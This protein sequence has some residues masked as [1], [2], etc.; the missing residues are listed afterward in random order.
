MSAVPLLANPVLLLQTK[1][2]RPHAYSDHLPRPRLTQQLNQGLRRKLTLVAAPAGYG[3]TTAVIQWLDTLS[4]QAHRIAWLSLDESDNDLILFVHYLVAAIQQ[5]HPDSCISTLAALHNPVRQP[6]AQ[7]ANLLLNDLVALPT[8]LIL[9]IDDYHF[10]VTEEIHQFLDRLL[11]HLPSSLNLVLISRTEPPLS[12]PRLRVRRQMNELRIAELSFSNAETER[13]LTQDSS[14]FLTPT[15]I[16]ALQ[17]RSQGWIAGLYLAK[18]SLGSKVNEQALLKQLQASNT[19]IMDYLITEVLAQQPQAVQTF[20][21]HTAILRRFCRPLCEALLGGAFAVNDP[22]FSHNQTPVS[23]LI[24]QLARQHLFIISLDDD[25]D[26]YRYHHLFQLMLSRRLQQKL[27]PSQISSLHKQAS[28]WFATEGYIDEALHH[29]LIAEDLPFAIQLIGQQRIQLLDQFDYPTLERWLSL[30]PP[31]VIEQHPHLLL[32]E[33]WITYINNRWTIPYCFQRA[34]QLE[35]ALKNSEYSLTESQRTLLQAE[36]LAV[37]GTGYFWSRDHQQVLH[38]YQQI[39]ATLP[40]SSCLYARIQICVYAVFTLWS[41]QRVFEALRLIDNEIQADTGRF[42][43]QIQWLRSHSSL[44][45]FLMGDLQQAH[46]IAQDTLR[47]ASGKHEHHPRVKAVLFISLGFIHYEWNNLET[48]QH[49]FSRIEQANSTQYLHSQLALAWICEVQEQNS[50]SAQQIID[51]LYDWA[52]ATK[53]SQR[54][55]NRIDSFQARRLYWQGDVDLALNTLRNIEIIKEVDVLAGEESATTLAMILATL[56]QEHHWQEAE[57]LLNELWAFATEI[58]DNIPAQA[59]I[60]ALQALLLQ[61]QGQSELALATLGRA[62]QLGKPSGLIRTFVD[63]GTPMAT[64][65]YQLL[66]RGVEPDYLGQ[67]LAAFSEARP[68]K[69]STQRVQQETQEQLVEPLTRRE[70]DVLLLLAQ[71][72]SNKKIA[73]QLSISPLT[74]KRHTINIY[75]KLSVSSRRDAV[76]KARALGIVPS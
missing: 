52:S 6:E 40:P 62:V 28:R 44:L 58:S 22:L 73:Q 23:S 47:L 70:L 13:F 7:L 60:S 54:V 19:H 34:Q 26:W 56:D 68:K 65:L 53:A 16:A 48:A 30:L 49:Y 57:I 66:E 18:L 20:L 3:K 27:S 21:L 72:L 67:V 33:F 51:K 2:Y 39:I 69:T 63:L 50:A 14:K 45:R 71:E 12:L 42:N 15:T 1:L 64:L 11:T 74:V 17:E 10:V 8:P 46:Q 35:L 76:Y 37:K 32:L 24:D 61:R 75:Q 9:V 55:R 59:R 25:G 36:I 38:C 43:H 41:Q 5:C 4:A 29:A 31:S